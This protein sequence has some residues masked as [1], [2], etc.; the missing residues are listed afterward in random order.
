[1]SD[2]RQVLAS[3]ALPC[4]AAL[5][6]WALAP[7]VDCT[8]ELQAPAVGS[9]RCSELQHVGTWQLADATCHNVSDEAAREHT[10][11]QFWFSTTCTYLSDMK[12]M[13]GIKCRSRRQGSC[14]PAATRTIFDVRGG[15]RACARCL[16]CFARCT[17]C[18]FRRFSTCGTGMRPSTDPM[19]HC[20]H[21]RR[22]LNVC[23]VEQL[24][25]CMMRHS[26]LQGTLVFALVYMCML[27]SAG[28]YVRGIW[29]AC[30]AF[31][32]MLS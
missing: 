1:M 25:T 24:R 17:S 2:L 20:G 19:Q 21:Q 16:L 5:R 3:G 13:C 15:V 32:T 29:K 14:R 11:T 6:L 27:C 8:H 10:R 9:Q 28:A 7:V 18:R 22:I 12:C 31:R 23:S 30:K 26:R 4:R